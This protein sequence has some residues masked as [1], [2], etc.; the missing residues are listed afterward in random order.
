MKHLFLISFALL[1]AGGQPPVDE[2]TAK[3]DPLAWPRRA[4]AEGPFTLDLP[5]FEL[6]PQASKTR[7]VPK[8]PPRLLCTMRIREAPAL[9][10]KG[11]RKTGPV[12]ETMARPSACVAE[13]ESPER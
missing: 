6:Q 1:T 2:A 5:P 12:D 3:A 4:P 13:T 10:R 7:S 11:V 8:A 9:D